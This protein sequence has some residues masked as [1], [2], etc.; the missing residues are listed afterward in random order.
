MEIFFSLRRPGEG[1]LNGVNR[2]DEG[3]ADENERD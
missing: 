2:H 3:R 1:G